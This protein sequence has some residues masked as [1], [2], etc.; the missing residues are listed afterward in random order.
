MPKPAFTQIVAA[1]F[2]SRPGVW[3]DGRELSTVGGAYAW[4]SR[5][6]DCR[7]ELGMA[8]ENRQRRIQTADGSRITVSEYR[9][10]VPQPSV[11]RAAAV[12]REQRL[13]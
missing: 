10:G 1:Y 13:F 11:D 6:S 4:R 9:Y 2:K 5:I 3:V 8:I 12:S 7:R